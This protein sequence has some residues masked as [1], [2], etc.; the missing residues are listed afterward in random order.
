MQDDEVA[1]PNHSHY[2]GMNDRFAMARPDVAYSYGTRA[3][4]TLERCRDTPIHAEYYARLWAESHGYKV[5]KMQNFDFFRV[6]A[7]GTVAPG[8]A[9]SL[10]GCNMTEMYQFKMPPAHAKAVRDHRRHV[11]HER[12]GW[13]ALPGEGAQFALAQAD[14]LHMRSS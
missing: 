10:Q 1:I 12:S 4:F 9:M 11:F 6:R 13:A 5:T 2:K 8:D 3:N 7:T 14:A